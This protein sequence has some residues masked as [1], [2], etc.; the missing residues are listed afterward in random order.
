MHLGG[1]ALPTSLPYARASYKLTTVDDVVGLL[2]VLEGKDP[3][4]RFL[5]VRQIEEI[6]KSVEKV[7]PE[8]ERVAA[9]RGE[10]SKA[11]SLRDG[12]AHGQATRKPFL[13]REMCAIID[14]RERQARWEDHRAHGFE[15]APLALR[16]LL[17]ARVR[18]TSKRLCDLPSAATCQLLKD[19]VTT[20]IVKQW[21]TNEMGERPSVSEDARQRVIGCIRSSMVRPHGIESVASLFG[22]RAARI[23]A[24][25]ARIVESAEQELE[26]YLRPGTRRPSCKGED[27][28]RE[29]VRVGVLPKAPIIEHAIEVIA[30]RHR[31]PRDEVVRAVLKGIEQCADPALRNTELPSQLS[32]AI[33]SIFV[34][35]KGGLSVIRGSEGYLRAIVPALKNVVAGCEDLIPTVNQLLSPEYREGVWLRTSLSGVQREVLSL[36]GAWFSRSDTPAIEKGK[37]KSILL[38]ETTGLNPRALIETSLFWI[39]KDHKLFS[40]EELR[41][42]TLPLLTDPDR[43]YLYHSL[44][45]TAQKERDAGRS[46]ML[47]ALEM[48]IT[49][50]KEGRFGVAE[51]VAA[52]RGGSLIAI[53]REKDLGNGLWKLQRDEALT[54]LAEVNTL[55][56][57]EPERVCGAE[58]EQKR[59]ETRLVRNEKCKE[60]RHRRER[61]DEIAGNYRARQGKA[62]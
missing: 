41:K 37:L 35:H 54:L 6:K 21:I 19:G 58:V 13:A 32:R 2:R 51:G 59:I 1:R 30:E 11:Q 56:G 27:A 28:S 40:T 43:E 12:I 5:E 15:D 52:Y 29:G 4:W 45:F 8:G 20:A 3:A 49:L 53:R 7:I 14:A 10:L 57:G 24:L 25:G 16:L 42:V 38:R 48:V 62:A 18:T 23:D 17:N 50:L 47:G 60:S 22:E 34:S 33:S 46:D 61:L 44:H 39:C 55:C 31:Y 9:L 36:V 26:F